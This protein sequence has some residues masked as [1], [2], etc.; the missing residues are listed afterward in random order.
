MKKYAKNISIFLLLLLLFALPLKAS[1]FGLGDIGGFFQDVGGGIAGFGKIIANPIGDI[2]GAIGNAIFNV[3]INLLF[4]VPLAISG[5]LWLLAAGLVK[6]VLSPGFLGT[7]ITSP[8][9]K[10]V[11]EMWVMVRDFTNMFFVLALVAIGLGTALRYGEYQLQKALPRLIFIALL[12]NFTPVIVGFFIDAANIVIRFLVS[13]TAGDNLLE[14]AKKAYD[15]NINLFKSVFTDSAYETLATAT[16][17]LIFNVIAIIVYILYFLLYFF[18]YVALIIL[19]ILS[20]LA[21]FCFILPATRGFWNMW[22]KQ[23]IAWLTVGI[24]GAFFIFLASQMI[25]TMW[26]VDVNVGSGLF[27]FF[28]EFINT[29]VTALVPIVMLVMGFLFSIQTSAM[30]AQTVIAY[31]K[32]AGGQIRQ[33]GEKRGAEMLRTSTRK[34]T[35]PLAKAEKRTERM[36]LFGREIPGTGALRQAGWYA[37]TPLRAGAKMALPYVKEAEAR[38]IEK[39]EVEAKKIKTPEKM[40]AL[41]RAPAITRAQ[42]IGRL[43]AA[44]ENKQLGALRTLGLKDEEIERIA[45]EALDVA[46]GKAKDIV[47]ALGPESKAGLREHLGRKG[48][49]DAQ[50]KIVGLQEMTPA[51]HEKYGGSYQIKYMTE[52]TAKDIERWSPNELID[53]NTKQLKEE[54][55]IAL[56][57]YGRGEQLRA[58]AQNLGLQGVEAVMQHLDEVGKEWLEQFNSTLL[59]YLTRNQAQELGY[60]EPRSNP[61]GLNKFPPPPAPSVGPGPIPPGGPG[62]RRPEPPAMGPT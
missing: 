62:P 44:I 34:V 54:I 46:P 53:K 2:A 4:Q 41:L 43:S 28:T 27:K 3:L 17:Q 24:A 55:K 30:G 9:N 37:T 57:E 7:P 15:G 18:R 21:F 48:F 23:F 1:A 52:A 47:S 22:W 5:T 19:F 16:A 13:E 20:P 42:K 32:R 59:R 51:E 31:S 10:A 38:A 35:E 40:Y 60:R 6:F 56:R 36:Q 14:M 26:N 50:L 39:E 58:I 8:D 61:E 33:F 29:F 45:E 12:I 11:Y 25:G 49:T